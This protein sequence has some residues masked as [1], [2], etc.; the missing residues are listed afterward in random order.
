MAGK[1][2][3]GVSP[4]LGPDATGVGWAMEYVLIDKTGKHSLAELRTLQDW[5]VQ[6]QIRTV[7]G[8]AEVAPVGGFVK[9]YQVTIDPDKLLAYKIPINKV[10]EQIRRSNQEV[11]GRVL[12]FTGT[13]YMVRGRGYIQKPAD[14]ENIA[15]GAQPDG[16]PI[17]VRHLG[18]VQIGPDIRRGVVDYNGM[19]DAAG[20]IVVVRFGESVYDVLDRVKEIIRQTVQPTL[21]Q[22]VELVVTYD[23][24]TLIKHSVETLREKLIEESI[25][26]S[27]ICLIFLFHVR[28][29]LV[30]I[31]TLPLAV[32]MALVAMQWI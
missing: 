13:E 11:G 16:T 24:S 29:A 17:L 6:F 15:V 7:P 21:P 28:S 19:G 26:V 32:L 18:V 8:V 20:G 23:R 14:I 31:I 3:Q 22:G 9:Q 25:I 27:L 4:K 30:A 12:E 1:L 2:P 5:Q 10:V